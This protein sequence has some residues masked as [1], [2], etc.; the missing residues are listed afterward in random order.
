M[1]KSPMCSHCILVKVLQVFGP[2]LFGVVLCALTS[3]MAEVFA[4]AWVSCAC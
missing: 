4:C 2:N 1:A 3:G